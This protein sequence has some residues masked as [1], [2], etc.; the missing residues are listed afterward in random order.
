MARRTAS[1]NLPDTLFPDPT[2]SRASAG[3]RRMMVDLRATPDALTGLDDG[4]KSALRRAAARLE[5]AASGNA[6]ALR[7]AIEANHRL[8]EAIA[9]AIRARTAETSSYGAHGRASVGGG[10]PLTA[11]SASCRERVGQYV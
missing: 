5:T 9:R 8:M 10:A 4:R 1:T 6:I 7:T 11:G 2:L 3:Y